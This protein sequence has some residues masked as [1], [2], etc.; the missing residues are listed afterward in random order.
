MVYNPLADTLQNAFSI[1][2]DKSIFLAAKAGFLER[3]DDWEKIKSF[4]GQELFKEAKARGLEIHELRPRGQSAD[5]YE[6][7]I[8]GNTFTFKGL[9]RPSGYNNVALDWSDDKGILKEKLRAAGLPVADGGSACTWNGALKIFRRINKPV[10]VKPRIGSRGRHTTTFVYTEEQLR[11]AYRIAK[12]LCSWMVIEEHLTGAVYRGTVIDGKCIGVLGGDPP[13][14]I[15]D[16]IHTITELIA[17]KN[18]IKNPHVRDI[19]IDKKMELFLGRSNYTLD[20][21]LPS[22]MRIDV[23]EKIGVSYGGS[24]FEATP[25]THPDTIKMFEDAAAVVNDPL[26]G[27]DFII[28]DITRSWKEQR[29]GILECN[30]VPFINLHHDPL[31]GEPINAA[32]YVWDMIERYAAEKK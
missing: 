5:L 21:I 12:Q 7:T 15:G 8:A 17:L 25:E 28:P 11:E 23:N 14:V 2:S 10:I 22:G 24:S 32:K 1:L 16:G 13:H 3:N 30:A 20:T 19:A 27:F 18:E 9:P 29:C 31:R 26:L 4:R 6:V